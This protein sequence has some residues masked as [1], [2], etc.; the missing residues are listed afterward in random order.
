M[1]KLETTASPLI[2]QP[3]PCSR[4]W[5]GGAV[6]DLGV[7]MNGCRG[8]FTVNIKLLHYRCTYIETLLLQT[9]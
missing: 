8:V 7:V 3:H 1:L 6:V 9:V 5:T 2:A 4:G